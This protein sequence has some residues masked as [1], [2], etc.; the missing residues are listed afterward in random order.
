MHVFIAG[1]AILAGL[2]W[3]AVRTH[4]APSI[5]RGSE[6]DTLVSLRLI[7]RGRADSIVLRWAPAR[8]AWL[9]WK[10]AGCLVQRRE[11]QMNAPV[12]KGGWKNLVDAPLR[13]WRIT[14]WMDRRDSTDMW[15]TLALTSVHHDSL[16]FYSPD[17]VAG[18]KLPGGSD[19]DAA[20]TLS[21]LAADREPR[22]ADALGLRYVDRDVRSGATY[23]YRVMLGERRMRGDTATIR[24][25]AS[26][27]EHYPAPLALEAV[28][29]HMRIL[30]RWR[31]QDPY[32]YGY[33]H[34]DRSEDGGATYRRITDAPVGAQTG[35][36]IP[37]VSTVMF[38]DTQVVN[39]HAYTYRI[40]GLTPFAEL[41]E[42]SEVTA[43][44]RDGIAPEYAVLF[45]PQDQ[46]SGTILLTWEH[47]DSTFT[48]LA[49]FHVQRSKSEE[50]PYH[51]I[52]P[53]LLP[54]AQRTFVDATA[55][56]DEQWYVIVS[57][58]AAGNAASSWPKQRFVIDSIPPE[59]PVGFTALL[60]SNGVV[61]LDW[62]PN[63]ETDI[64]GYQLFR[65][66]TAD[67]EM[68]TLTPVFLR[69]CGFLDT[70]DLYV[71][72]G[73]VWYDIN[74]IDKNGNMSVSRG[75][76]R[77]SLPDII[78]PSAPA[79]TGV[80][81]QDTGVFLAWTVPAHEG[82]T[83]LH[84]QRRM[85]NQ[86]EAGVSR[87]FAPTVTSLLDADLA[88]GVTYEYL[89]SAQDS[90][91]NRSDTSIAVATTLTWEGLPS[92][93][94]VRAEYDSSSRAVRLTWQTPALSDTACWIV[95]YRSAGSGP[96][97][98]YRAVPRG[99]SEFLDAFLT[100]EPRH[101]YGVRLRSPRGEESATHA[102]VS[103]ETKR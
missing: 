77:V 88:A 71:G 75:R 93:T 92:P 39:N 83:Q 27:A 26:D 37:G 89:L 101:G 1:I 17:T 90:T 47:P 18:G 44:P 97:R 12:T 67:G 62:K 5:S 96:L 76:T 56:V 2:L 103:V 3:P 73:A 43:A 20:W 58:D 34:I 11:V 45:D 69:Q 68:T 15:L 24:V 78:P 100:T 28:P 98:L 10:R 4:S 41:G 84:L 42:A 102:P 16:R 53:N 86:G 25:L 36:E 29:G 51:T 59:M 21:L 7:A 55:T 49:G 54:A 65:S 82:I 70:L 95:V 80:M 14:D 85:L 33:Y 38:A 94:Q 23:E 19:E 66:Y 81:V 35:S 31:E 52:T 91:G 46:D 60:D 48:D 32:R 74:A 30:L 8:K 99:S 6:T 61:H 79:F 63:T 72:D 13:P 50:G 22:T 87:S 9:R 40:R 64:Y 57:V